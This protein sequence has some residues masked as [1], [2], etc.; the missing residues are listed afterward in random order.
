[1]SLTV[2]QKLSKL[3]YDSFDNK[4]IGLIDKY[5][6]ELSYDGSKWACNVTG[7]YVQTASTRFCTYGPNPIKALDEA[8]KLIPNEVINVSS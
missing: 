3:R 1:M 5:H 6:F 8:M 7:I 4:Y 2:E